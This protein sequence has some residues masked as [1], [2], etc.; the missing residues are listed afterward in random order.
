MSKLSS[1][2]EYAIRITISVVVCSGLLMAASCSGS[3]ELEVRSNAQVVDITNVRITNTPKSDDG[4]EETAMRLSK[5]HEN[6]NCKE[7]VSAF[8][9]SF[10][11]FNHLYGYDDETGARRLYSKSEHIPYFFDCPDVA[12]RDRIG[13]VIRIGI[14]GTWDA[15]SIGSFQEAAYELIK[16]HSTEAKGILDNLP[17]ENAASF[18]YFLFDGPHPNDKRNVRKFELLLL[19]LG[20]DSKQSKLLKEQF[21]KL[22]ASDD[23]HG[24]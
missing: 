3:S 22:S 16:G 5:L 7:F 2:I 4:L 19:N 24:R 20:K 8:P 1:E 15:D 9:N 13:K 18:W 6:N 23:G 17:E 21:Q 12:D 14:N 11:D 10:E